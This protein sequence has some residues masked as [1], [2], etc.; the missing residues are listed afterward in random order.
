[1]YNCS[2]HSSGCQALVRAYKPA[3]AD[4]WKVHKVHS[5]HTGCSGGSTPG[6]SAALG[7]IARQALN[8]NP[9]L[10]GIGLKRKIERDTGIKVKHR[11]ATR[12]KNAARK[13]AHTAVTESYQQ[14]PS[15]C[16]NLQENC[17][18]TVAEVQV[19]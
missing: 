9:D 8:D 16:K 10:Q 11:T 17:P 12:L 4:E 19:R 7:D 1:M 6:R 13:D 3:K 18:G 15:F 5:D 2:G 14:L